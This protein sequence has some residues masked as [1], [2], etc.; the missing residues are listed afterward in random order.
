[1][2]MFDLGHHLLADD[3]GYVKLLR[4]TELHH[5]LLKETETGSS[6][7]LFMAITRFF[8]PLE[9]K[10]WCKGERGKGSSSKPT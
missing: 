6:N 9:S 5:Q 10:A 4:G 8:D 7:V 2:H 3:I 1:M